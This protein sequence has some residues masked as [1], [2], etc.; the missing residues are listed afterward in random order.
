VA[1]R[2]ELGQLL[3]RRRVGCEHLAHAHADVE[4]DGVGELDRTH[5]HSECERRFVDVS[6]A[7]PSS[8]Q[9]IASIRYGASTRLT[10]KPGALFTG[11]GSLSIWRTNAAAGA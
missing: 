3:R 5:R 11:S 6:G 2:D 7:M 1:G 4:A 10:R 8:T 9:R